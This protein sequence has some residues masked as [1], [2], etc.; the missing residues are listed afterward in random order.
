L[1]INAA[2]D[3]PRAVGVTLIATDDNGDRYEAQ[4]ES[5]NNIDWTHTFTP[6][7]VGLWEAPMTIKVI[8]RYADGTTGEA[9]EFPIVLIDPSGYIYHSEKGEEWKLPGATVVLQYFDPQAE[10]WVEMTD[11]AYPGMLSPV[12]NPQVTGEDGRYAWDVAEGTY[13]VKVSRPGFETTISRE[14]VVPPPVLDLHVGLTPTDRVQ[15]EINENGV[16]D[17]KTYGAPV[18]IEFTST[19][20]EAGIRYITY[21]IDNG[22]EIKVNGN[23]A[24]LPVINALGEHKVIL[25]S[26]DHAG[27]ET[28]EEFNFKIEDQE[29][30][31]TL[32]TQAIEKSKTA[33]ISIKAALEKMNTNSSVTLINEELNKA[34]TANDEAKVKITRLKELLA[35]Y[36]SPKIPATQLSALRNYVLISEQQNVIAH[37]KLV[38]AINDTTISSKKSKT[39]D[40][41]RANGYSVNYLE[42]VKSNFKAYG[43]K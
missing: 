23:Q 29:N 12:T 1:T 36:N 5:S 2:F 24:N 22:T 20:D 3:S 15:P 25:T 27:N 38:A 30:M 8:P 32:V 19:D 35:V 10:T 26:V 7:Q 42:F 28:V 14:V 9:Q 37:N 40:A 11:E 17:G 4:M 21:K 34:L 31:M 13:R 18:T 43:I 6:S 33:Q 39:S 41:L 16:V